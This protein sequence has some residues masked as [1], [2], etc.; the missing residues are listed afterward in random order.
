VVSPEDTS[1]VEREGYLRIRF[2]GSASPRWADFHYLWLR[3]NC[4]CCRHPETGER[5]LCPSTIPAPIRPAS[6]GIRGADLVLEWK[7]DGDAHISRF[8][9]DWLREHA[10][11]AER[12]E[13]A[14]PLDEL[15]RLE[16]ECAQLGAE[17]AVPCMERVTTDGAVVVRRAGPDTDA[18]IQAFEGGGLA[19]T[20]SHF[21]RIEDLRTDNTTNRNTDQLGYTD[22]PVDFHTD[23]PFIARPPRYQMLHCVRPAD[24]GGANS[25]ADGLQ[26]ARYLR[27]LD[28]E[29]FGLL[30]SVP[31]RF[32]RRQKEFESLQARPIVELRNGEPH[33]VRSSYFTYAPHEMAFDAMAAWYRAYAHFVAILEKHH[34]RLHL[35]AGDFLLYDNFRMLH[36]RTAFHG[37]RWL[38]GVYFDP[39]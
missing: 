13:V 18:L 15:S 21:G 9:L 38:R 3:H 11:A 37:P 32:H 19:V 29:A 39:R 17:I 10:Y 25:V 20:H 26:A 8:R 27:S 22:A 6:A 5:I 23:Q 30:T 34:V 7:Q 16:V 31:I 28:A 33:Q 12:E 1:V 4:P 2:A 35:E 36:A 24:R 14:P